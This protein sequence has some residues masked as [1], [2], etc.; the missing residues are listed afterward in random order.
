MSKKTFKIIIGLIIF[1]YL[2]FILNIGIYEEP[3]GEWD[4]QLWLYCTHSGLFTCE[5]LKQVY[6]ICIRGM[7]EFE[8]KNCSYF[9][10]KTQFERAIDPRRRN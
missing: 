10:N 1:I 6:Y 8:N 5:E 2:I 3:K 9:D 4:D 7:T